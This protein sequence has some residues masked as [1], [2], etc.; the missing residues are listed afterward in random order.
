MKLHEVIAKRDELRD[1]V[2]TAQAMLDTAK[3]ELAEFEAKEISYSDEPETTVLAKQD[4][5]AE[6]PKATEGVKPKAKKTAQ[7]TAQVTKKQPAAS[8]GASLP[9]LKKAML[10]VMGEETMTSGEIVEALEAKGWLPAS[11]DPRQYVSFM[12]SSN[13][14]EVFERT[15]KRGQYRVRS[16]YLATQGGKSKNGKKIVTDEDLEKAW[17]PGAKPGNVVSDPYE[18]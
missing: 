5:K 15:E 6:E 11:K 18:S 4:T 1:K 2:S 9:P 14:P 16:E 12:L 10:M 3:Q 17:G 13:T 8:K 7:A